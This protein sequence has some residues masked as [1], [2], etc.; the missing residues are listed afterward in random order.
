M[1]TPLNQCDSYMESCQKQ[2][3]ALH[4]SLLGSG[5]PHCAQVARTH[6][7]MSYSSHLLPVAPAAIDQTIPPLLSSRDDR[8]PARE[9]P[10][11]VSLQPAHQVGPIEWGHGSCL[12]QP[13][14]AHRTC[15]TQPPAVRACTSIWKL[16]R[17]HIGTIIFAHSPRA[18]QNR[19]TR[20]ASRISL[21]TRLLL[22]YFACR[23]Q[24]PRPSQAL[25]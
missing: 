19:C 7:L 25:G 17:T 6:G 9:G 22:R 1:L 12:Y 14:T 11:D 15:Q 2:N 24:F 5:K 20:F 10:L 21:R 23:L 18:G 8:A 13:L 16:C 3:P 4:C